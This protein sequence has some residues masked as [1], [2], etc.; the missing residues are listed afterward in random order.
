KHLNNG[1]LAIEKVVGKV[2]KDRFSSLV[3]AIWWIMEF[4]NKIDDNKKVSMVDYFKMVNG[5]NVFGGS[6][7]QMD[8][9]QKCF[10]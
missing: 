1:N 4:D 10:K 7:R 6:G 8:S 5:N 3:Y 9:L 2:D